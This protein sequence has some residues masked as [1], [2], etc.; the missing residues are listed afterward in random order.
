[1][2]LTMINPAS[3][4]FEIMELPVVTL[5]CKQTANGKELLIADK[6]FD[7]TLEHKDKLVNKIWLFRYPRSCY[8]I[9]ADNRSEFKLYFEY[10]YESYSI[11][12]KLI[13]VKNP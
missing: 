13:T 11:T 12:H 1:M 3:S 5:L 8:L 6:I 4:W 2:A 10:L 9:Y 7:K